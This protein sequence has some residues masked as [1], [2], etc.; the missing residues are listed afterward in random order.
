MKIIVTGGSGFVGSR[1]LPRLAAGGHDVILLTRD[2]ESVR[3][4]I[5]RRVAVELW[6]GKTVGVWARQVDGA[7]AVLNFAGESIGGKRWTAAQKGRIIKSRVDGTTAIVS[8][9]GKAFKKPAT[10]INASAVGFYGPVEDGDVGEDHPRGETFLSET[11]EQWEKAAREAEKSDVRVV[12]LRSGVVLGKGGALERMVLPFKLFAGCPVG[13]GRQWF[14]WIHLDDLVGVVLFALNNPNV[15][16]PVNVVAPQA[17]TMKEFSAE[18]G[19]VLHRPSWIPV[20]GFVLK[21][22]LGEMSEMLLTGQ[23]VV[24]GV[25]E[26]QG[27]NFK[28]PQVAQAL[29]NVLK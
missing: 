7:D 3:S 8:A 29:S 2:P 24:P 1:L 23:R 25:L 21:V 12:L 4:R 15:S 17:M 19:R 11:V 9:I 22:A 27:Y 16:G 10:L 26:R 6:D 18:L 28:F 20:P 5:D 13:S 14:P